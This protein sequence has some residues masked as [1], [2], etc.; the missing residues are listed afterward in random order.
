MR[1]TINTLW[2]FI[3]GSLTCIRSRNTE[4]MIEYHTDSIN[5]PADTFEKTINRETPTL[6]N[7]RL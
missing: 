5:K 7:D 2:E 1:Q 6:G 3:C 4:S